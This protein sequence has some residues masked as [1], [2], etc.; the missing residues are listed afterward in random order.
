MMQAVTAAAIY[1]MIE[2][3]RADIV[4]EFDRADNIGKLLTSSMRKNRTS[5]NA[6]APRL[7]FVAIY[8]RRPPEAPGR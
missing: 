8:F 3:A 7:H 1:T 2:T 4:G 6:R 5:L